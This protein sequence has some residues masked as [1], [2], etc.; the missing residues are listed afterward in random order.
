M[1]Y[2]NRDAVSSLVVTLALGVSLCVWIGVEVFLQTCMGV[3]GCMC[4]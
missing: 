2:V 1:K 4:G 3:F